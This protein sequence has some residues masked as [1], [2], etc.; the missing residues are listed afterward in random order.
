MYMPRSGGRVHVPPKDCPRQKLHGDFENAPWNEENEEKADDNEVE[1]HAAGSFVMVT[2]KF[3]MPLQI[4]GGSH[5]SVRAVHQCPAKKLGRVS[6]VRLVTVPPFLV[7]VVNGDTF[8]ASSAWMGA[9]TVFTCAADTDRY[10]VHF[11]KEGYS[12]LDGVRYVLDFKPRFLQSPST[13]Q[14]DLVQLVDSVCGESTVVEHAST[15]ASVPPERF[16]ETELGSSADLTPQGSRVTRTR[17]APRCSQKRERF[18]KA[19]Q[20]FLD[21]WENGK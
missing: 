3:E 1:S 17:P 16:D 4:C 9:S 13:G 19:F 20:V 8:H 11:V 14:D 12:L 5:R 18:E 10:Q 21:G 7:V 15:K 6:V 2:G